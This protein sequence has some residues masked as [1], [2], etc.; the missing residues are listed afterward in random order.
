MIFRTACPPNLERPGK[1][2]PM[3]AGLGALGR[4]RVDAGCN[5]HARALD[6][7]CRPERRNLW[8]LQASHRVAE[9]HYGRLVEI[10]RRA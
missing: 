5:E 4:N 7:G 8:C 2:S 1:S 9:A 10:G 6:R 3:T